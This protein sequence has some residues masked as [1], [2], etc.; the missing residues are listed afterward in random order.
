MAVRKSGERTVEPVRQD[1]SFAEKQ[2]SRPARLRVVRNGHP[3]DLSP[4]ARFQRSTTVEE[5]VGL[6]GASWGRVGAHRATGPLRWSS[7]RDRDTPLSRMENR[8]HG[9][10]LGAKLREFCNGTRFRYVFESR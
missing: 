7:V 1:G 9:A 6:A 2:E 8:S 4:D 3:A 5:S 10:S